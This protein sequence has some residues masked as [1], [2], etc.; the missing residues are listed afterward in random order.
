MSVA[1]PGAGARIRALLHDECAALPR[2]LRHRR[3]LDD[4]AASQ[5][6]ERR[7]DRRSQARIDHEVLVQPAT[8]NP[9]RG[10]RD[11]ATL[12]LGQPR[13]EGLAPGDG[14]CQC[15]LSGRDPRLGGRACR[16]AG[17]GRLACRLPGRRD[18]RL[19]L[20]CGLATSDRGGQRGFA[21]SAVRL[22]SR[23]ARGLL[24]GTPG[25]VGE[26]A[27]SRLELSLPG[28]RRP[29]DRRELLPMRPARGTQP[30]EFRQGP[31]E[32]PFRLGQGRVEVQVAGGHG[33]G[34]DPSGCGDLGLRGRAI[35]GEATPVA[36]DRLALGREPRIA[37]LGI[38]QRSPG[39]VVGLATEALRG[40]PRAEGICQERSGRFG[41]LHLGHRPVRDRP[42]C[43]A[44][45]RRRG[46]TGRC[47]EPAGMRVQEHGRRELIR[48]RSTT[49]LLLR[50]GGQP[51]RLR[52]QLGHDVLDA[53]EVR[54]RFDQLI[55]GP[56]TT[57]FV[58]PHARDLLEQRPPF[59]R[60][61]RERLVDH[62]LA[63]EQ[64]RVVGEMPGVEQ[65][66]EV[67]Q[68]DPLLV[69]QVVVLT[70]A[71]QAPPELEDRVVDRQQAIGVVDHERDVGHALRRAPVRP[72]P[73]DVLGLARPEGASLLPQGP[74]QGVGEVALARAVRPHHGADPAAELDV[75]PFGE[76]LEPLEPECEQAGR[77][78]PVWTV[79]S[80]P[81]HAPMD[82][83]RSA[84][85]SRS[86]ASEAAAVSA[87]RRDG[88]SPTPRAT[89]STLTS[90]RKVRSWSGPVTWTR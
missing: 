17:L 73:D 41:G 34:H 68:A 7:L 43:F 72:G 31:R 12:L 84:A 46:R 4:V 18:R 1:G 53:R 6:G 8:A 65:V 74:A 36:L 51:S 81:A 49:R 23:G 78:R 28:R 63:D 47:L 20:E 19:G 61:K 24:V 56:S 22:G 79:R 54:L 39:G 50:L 2:E 13:V 5:F 35:L 11:P 52:S 57:P 89:P 21:R 10:L 86:I 30:G 83:E 60:S 59:L 38:G 9:S 87:V 71:V 48:R 90:I 80:V 75:G 77:G 33:R 82:S 25:D 27:A 40:R 55:L 29:A 26:A 16:L 67:A 85:Q 32:L 69:Q 70:R 44:P 45:A 76:R 64:E 37:Q 62:P 3:C 14:G 15:R 42:R 66:D 58:T 88:P